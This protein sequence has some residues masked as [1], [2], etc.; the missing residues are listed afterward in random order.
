VT[1]QRMATQTQGGGGRPETG[2]PATDPD[3]AAE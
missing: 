2:T 1:Q 3:K